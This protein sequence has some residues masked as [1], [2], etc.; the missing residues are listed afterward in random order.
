MGQEGDKLAMGIGTIVSPDG[1]IVT[2]KKNFDS[3]LL[4]ATVD[5]LSY[6]VEVIKNDKG[7]SMVLGR[8]VPV[9]SSSVP[10]VFVPVALGNADALKIGQ[11]AII[12][13]GRDGRTVAAGLVTNLDT[14]SVTDKDTKVETKILDNIGISQRLAGTSNGAPIITLS[15]EVVGFVSIDESIGSQIGVPAFEVKNLLAVNA[16]PVAPLKK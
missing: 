2:D 1:L 7:G 8:L 12:L 13:G 9:A 4:S 5:G 3:G 14:H 16:A 11:T 6:T 15:G 10:A